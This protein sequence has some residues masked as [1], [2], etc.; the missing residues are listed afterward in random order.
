MA[1]TIHFGSSRRYIK[2]IPAGCWA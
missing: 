1:S 2:V